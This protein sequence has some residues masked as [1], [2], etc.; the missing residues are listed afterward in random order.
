MRGIAALMAVI[1]AC[2]GMRV[3]AASPCGDMPCCKHLAPAVETVKPADC[4]AVEPDDG[5]GHDAL[6][7]AAART[8]EVAVPQEASVTTALPAPRAAERVAARP[9]SPP[10]SH[11]ARHTARLL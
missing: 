5:H 6:P 7:P 11:A 10:G 3:A 4:C 8:V 2:A 9:R 1:F